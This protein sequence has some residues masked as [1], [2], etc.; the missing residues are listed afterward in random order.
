MVGGYYANEKLRVDDNLAYGADYSRYANCV[1]ALNAFASNPLRSV[2]PFWRQ[3]HRRPASIRPLRLVRASLV[4]R[5]IA[6]LAA[7]N[8]PLATAI[9]GNITTLGAFAR[10]NNTGL[11]PGIPSVN[12]TGPTFTNSG[13]TNLGALMGAPAG[14]TGVGLNDSWRQT[15]NNWALF[16]HNIIS[17]TKELKL[18]IGARYTHEQKKLAGDLVDVGGLLCTA[19]SGGPFAALS[20]LPCVIPSIPGG[21]LDLSD[22]RSE[23]KLSGTVVLSYKPTDRLL[24]YAS[25]SRGYKAGGFNLDRSAL[26]RSSTTP[27]GLPGFGAICVT[28]TQVGC[29]S[30]I[31]SGADLEFKPE[32]NDAFEVGAKYNGRGFDINLAVFRQLFTNFQLNTFNGL[33]FIVENINSC[34]EDLGGAEPDNNP[35]TGACTGD[36]GAG[37]K[38][39]GFELE[40]FTRPINNVA[41]NGGITYAHTRYR[42]NL[43]GANGKAADER[44]VPASGT[45]D[46]ECAGLD[47][48]GLGCVDAAAGRVRPPRARLRRLPPHERLQHRLRPRHREDAGCPDSRKRSYRAPRWGRSL[49]DR[50]MGAESVRQ[51]LQ[52]GRIRRAGAGQR[53]DTGGRRWL[54]HSVDAAVRRIPGRAADLRCNSARE[55]RLPSRAS[56]CLRAG[57][58]AAATAACGRARDRRLHLRRLRRPSAARIQLKRGR[59][60]AANA[61]PLSLRRFRLRWLGSRLKKCRP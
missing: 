34:S 44:S 14:F 16:T 13:F 46:F 32:T 31:A 2:L 41:V 23:N 11:P 28:P 60:S 10:L 29:R 19:F 57:T 3:E 20:Q 50:G 18:T 24:T 7:G 37:V 12:F 8:I 15:S 33:N 39:Y 43:V 38:N 58:G 47:G 5:Y 25:Y 52:A 17:F 53:N 21:S 27:D 49:G 26:F 55:A 36:T 30:T 40:A 45:A 56:A 48:Y 59:G 51:E 4:S 61:G 22:K 9:A 54:H 42:D 6:A 35:V 1:I